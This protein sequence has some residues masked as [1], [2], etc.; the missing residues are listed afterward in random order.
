MPDGRKKPRCLL[1]AS[2]LKVLGV[3]SGLRRWS[4]RRIGRD[5]VV[6]STHCFIDPSPRK[7][8]GTSDGIDDVRRTAGV[9]GATGVTHKTGM[10]SKSDVD[11]IILNG[12]SFAQRLRTTVRHSWL[13]G[14]DDRGY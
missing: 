13:V 11:R 10:T 14:A 1:G 12:I 8:F 3:T 6:S 9:I 2:R 5:P 4:R 7:R